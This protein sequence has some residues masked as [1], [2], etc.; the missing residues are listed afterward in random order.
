MYFRSQYTARPVSVFQATM[1][2]RGAE[3][4]ESPWLGFGSSSRK[5]QRYLLD[6]FRNPCTWN[7]L[8]ME[9]S[10]LGEG[11]KMD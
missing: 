7:V 3:I 9:S 2:W 1:T 6:R 4:D 10:I 11:R 8:E 5:G